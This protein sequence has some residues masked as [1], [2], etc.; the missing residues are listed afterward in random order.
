MNSSCNRTLGIDLGKAR[1]GVALSDEL[2]WMAHPL[3]TLVTSSKSPQEIVA[4]A[5][6]HQ[7]NVVVIGLPRKLDGTDGLAADFCRD[8]AKKIEELTE[9]KV[10]LWDERL[11]T[12]AATRHLHE[13]GLKSKAHRAI[14]DQVA[15]QQILQSWMDASIVGQANNAS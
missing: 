6:K 4:L 10:V 7:V 5:E 1:I 11:T 2:G 15:A 12:A 9:I 13:R 8:F 14:I 3:Q